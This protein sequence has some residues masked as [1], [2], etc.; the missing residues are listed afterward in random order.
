M[1]SKFRSEILKG[2]GHLGDLD[3]ERRIILE[4][5]SQKQDECADWIHLAEDKDQ[6]RDFVNTAMNLWVP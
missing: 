5:I 4:W 1:H 3:V 2:R 6:R